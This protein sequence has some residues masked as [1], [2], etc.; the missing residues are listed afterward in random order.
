[1]YGHNLRNS[2]FAVFFYLRQS[3]LAVSL[4]PS[5]GSPLDALCTTPTKCISRTLSH[6]H[7][8]VV[9]GNT[10]RNRFRVLLLHSSIPWLMYHT[11]KDSKKKSRHPNVPAFCAAFMYPNLSRVLPIF[12]PKV[13]QS[14]FWIYSLRSI[15]ESFIDDD[16]EKKS[17]ARKRRSDAFVELF[18]AF[19]PVEKWK[20]RKTEIKLTLWKGNNL[21]HPFNAASYL[22]WTHGKESEA[23]ICFIYGFQLNVLRMENSNVNLFSFLR[24]DF[25]RGQAQKLLETKLNRFVAKHHH[26][27][28]RRWRTLNELVQMP[29]LNYE[30]VHPR[31]DDVCVMKSREMLS[32][33]RADNR[34][35]QAWS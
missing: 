18:F 20:S 25:E 35:W 15:R 10:T 34:V 3:L 19:A 26:N 22:R 13:I 23:Q 21:L 33:L 8:L 7:C 31:C 16:A 11:K 32:S 9:R 29:N 5:S 24:E 28:G 4:E 1:M 17:R 12:L 30:P 6:F 2:L 27:S 14:N